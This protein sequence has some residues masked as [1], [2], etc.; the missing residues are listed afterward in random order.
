MFGDFVLCAEGLR[1][2]VKVI[3]KR[4]PTPRSS[5]AF[6]DM[7]ALTMFADYRVPQILRAMG[8]LSWPR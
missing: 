5:Y 4:L 6:S 8:V 3:G 2:L 1:E 7:A